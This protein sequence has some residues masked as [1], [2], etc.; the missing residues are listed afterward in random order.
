M[1]GDEKQPGISKA[2]HRDIVRAIEEVQSIREPKYRWI[3]SKIATALMPLFATEGFEFER[4]RSYGDKGHDFV[5]S[6][7]NGE[8]VAVVNK[9][10]NRH[11]RISVSS[12]HQVIGSAQACG[13]NRAVIVSNSE[14]SAQALET[15]RR[16]LPLQVELLISPT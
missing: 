6:R 2:A 3:E 10:F 13:F 14:F 9:H 8:T 12:V 16:E 7:G 5:A 15:A 11:R 1:E 4:T